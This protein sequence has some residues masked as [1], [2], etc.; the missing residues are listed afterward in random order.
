MIIRYLIALP[1]LVIL[2]L[3][4]L[5]NT[6]PVQLGFWPTDL[7]LQVPLAVAVLGGMAITFLL[8]GIVVW[9]QLMAQRRRARRAENQVRRL[10]AQVAALQ[11]RERE[12]V[13]LPALR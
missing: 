11:N 10:E 9:F 6:Q 8:G 3:F 1:V 12:P 5:S 7:L 4:A 13:L 2:V